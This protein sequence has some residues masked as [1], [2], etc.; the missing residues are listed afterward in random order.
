MELLK[1]NQFSVEMAAAK[2]VLPTV[3]SILQKVNFLKVLA[4]FT[5][6]I[7]FFLGRFLDIIYFMLLYITYL[8]MSLYLPLQTNYIFPSGA[9]KHLQQSQLE[10][11]KKVTL[12]SDEF[13]KLRLDCKCSLKFS[14]ILTKLKIVKYRS[15]TVLKDKL[16]EV[17]AKG[18]NVLQE[19]EMRT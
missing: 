2:A 15:A 6:F 18:V 1:S 17:L 4:C 16:C 3:F 11:K 19:E 12:K 7:N 5:Q 13:Q 9:Y 8:E 10:K 14:L